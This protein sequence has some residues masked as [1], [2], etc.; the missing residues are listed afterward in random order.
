MQPMLWFILM[1]LNLAPKADYQAVV[2]PFHQS[3]L[4]GL[5]VAPGGE[6]A[7][8]RD[9]QGRTIWWQGKDLTYAGEG[10]LPTLSDEATLLLLDDREPW[11]FP[12]RA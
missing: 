9:L 1:A 3:G 5:S 10:G 8:S 12:R 4:A 6:L 11:P 2:F 7:L